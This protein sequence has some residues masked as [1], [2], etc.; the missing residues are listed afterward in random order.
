MRLLK[1][2]PKTSSGVPNNTATLPGTPKYQFKS[3]RQ[4]DLRRNLKACPARR[5]VYNSAINS[6]IFRAKDQ[7]SAVG[8]SAGR[9]HTCEPPRMHHC[10]LCQPEASRI[11]SRNIAKASLSFMVTKLILRFSTDRVAK[12][13]GSHSSHSD[14]NT[15]VHW[16]QH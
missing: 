5:V 2:N 3:T 12:A 9:P 11:M 1:R 8:N 13:I 14:R 7:F 10:P 15:T 4:L 16:S 6:R